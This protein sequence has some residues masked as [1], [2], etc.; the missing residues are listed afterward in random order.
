[1]QK[2]LHDFF[3]FFPNFRALLCI[4]NPFLD[5]EID[6]SIPRCCN[7]FHETLTKNCHKTPILTNFGS[8]QNSNSF[9]INGSQIVY[10]KFLKYETIDREASNYCVGP[11]WSQ[12]NN[13]NYE[14]PME[15]KLFIIP[16]TE[17][18]MGNRNR[19]EAIFPR[20]PPNYV[21]AEVTRVRIC[22]VFCYRSTCTVPRLE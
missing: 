9:W 8:I 3:P 5:F 2:C 15:M 7:G 6:S 12:R 4:P 20:F 11:G 17:V 10:K 13:F 16:E 18:P 1:M 21:G 19:S 22:R 14:K